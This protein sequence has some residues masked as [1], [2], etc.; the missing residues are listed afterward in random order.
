MNSWI[1]GFMDAWIHEELRDHGRTVVCVGVPA[2][3]RVET[4]RIGRGLLRPG[5]RGNARGP[6]PPTFTTP[7]PSSFIWAALA[8]Q[9][10]EF[11]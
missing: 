7:T 5:G 10:R 1:H 2:R 4:G 11:A 6:P 3:R 9:F 8:F